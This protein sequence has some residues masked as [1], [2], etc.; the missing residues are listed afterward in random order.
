MFIYLDIVGPDEARGV[1]MMAM[2]RAEAARVRENMLSSFC[3]SYGRGSMQQQLFSCSE[4][5]SLRVM[6]LVKVKI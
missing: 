1:V 2:D 4:Q 5:E 3:C 6:V